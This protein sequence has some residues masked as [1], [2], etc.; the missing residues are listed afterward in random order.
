MTD[1]IFFFVKRAKNLPKNSI[2][3]PEIVKNENISL[4]YD[5]NDHV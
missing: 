2:P 1:K 5:V 3:L 4:R